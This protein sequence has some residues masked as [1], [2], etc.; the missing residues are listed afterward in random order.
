[1]G[2]LTNYVFIFMLLFLS[3]S[4]AQFYQV[5]IVQANDSTQRM[6]LSYDINSTSYKDNGLVNPDAQLR[7]C[8]TAAVDLQNKY[9]TLAYADGTNLAGQYIEV[10]HFAVQITTVPPDLCVNVPLELSSFKAWY[11]SQPFVMIGDSPSDFSSATRWKLM[12]HRGWMM[13][14]YTVNNSV[15]GNLINVTVINATDFNGNLIIPNV[16]FLVVGLVEV[17]GL[18]TTSTAI[19]K[20]AQI[21]EL[22]L[23]AYVGNY[24]ILVNGIGPIKDDNLPPY[25]KIYTPATGSRYKT[26]DQIPFNFLITDN[27]EVASCWYT[28]N[29]N[30]YTLPNCDIS[31]ILP[32]LRAGTYVLTLYG[33]DFSDN[34]GSDTVTFTVTGAVGSGDWNFFPGYRPHPNVPP[35]H[36]FMIVPENVYLENN[37]PKGAQGDFEINSNV[38]LENVSCAVYWPSDIANISF[39]SLNATHI[40]PNVPIKATIYIEMSPQMALKLN[41]KYEALIECIGNYN[42]TIWMSASGNAY[43]T[44]K[45]PALYPLNTVELVYPAKKTEGLL[46]LINNGTADSAQTTI[47]LTGPYK[48][49]LWL[50]D[51]RP[52]V[53]AGKFT[54][55]GYTIFVPDGTEPGKYAIPIEV[56]EYGILQSKGKITINVGKRPPEIPPELPP[57]CNVCGILIAIIL[58]TLVSLRTFRWKKNNMKQKEH[59]R[60]PLFYSILSFLITFL[61]CCAIMLFLGLKL[62]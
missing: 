41:P 8:S 7:I 54:N 52:N 3:L 14:N 60:M 51:T 31:Y 13:G 55:V 21:A 53:K 1:M 17:D 12:K 43:L 26:T 4:F 18:T 33:K 62:I 61:A 5:S 38:E 22:T 45:R 44:V 50:N 19:V 29:S 47:V 10:T 59:P 40:Y 42:K 30:T 27:D 39:V 48:D 28:L 23:G 35:T 32:Q 2:K 58:A 37:Y 49:W 57:Q 56:Y 25:V 34:I 16:T 20:P 46:T 36:E 11:P 15:T 9:V 24:S 6:N